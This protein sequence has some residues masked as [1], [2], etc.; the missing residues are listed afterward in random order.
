MLK[1]FPASL[2]AGGLLAAGLSLAPQSALPPEVE[3]VQVAAL[4]EDFEM[5]VEETPKAPVANY[6]ACPPLTRACVDLSAN[7][8]WLQKDGKIEYGPVPINHGMPGWETP[9][10]GYHVMRHVKDEVSYEHNLDPM[11]WSTYFSPLGIAFHEGALDEQSHGCIHLS[12]QDAQ[13]YFHTLKVH[14]SVAVF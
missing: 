11:P 8:S 14:D 1:Y 10:G 7:L 13:H 2:A 5:P 12:G 6:A 4:G 9:K 3:E